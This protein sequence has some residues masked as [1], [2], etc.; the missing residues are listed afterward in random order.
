M[1]WGVNQEMPSTAEAATENKPMI[2]AERCAK[3]EY[4]PPLPNSAHAGAPLLFNS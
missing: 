4:V 2:A 3:E 1:C